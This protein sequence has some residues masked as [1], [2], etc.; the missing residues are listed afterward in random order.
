LL[1]N[2]I[3]H[4]YVMRFFAFS[5][6]LQIYFMIIKKGHVWLSIVFYVSTVVSYMSSS[7]GQHLFDAVTGAECFNN[8]KFKFKKIITAR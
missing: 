5:G 2:F 1:N 7:F 6:R 3:F 4:T 8:N